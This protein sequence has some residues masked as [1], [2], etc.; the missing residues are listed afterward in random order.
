[1]VMLKCA[2]GLVTAELDGH[3]IVTRQALTLAAG[4]S[5]RLIVDAEQVIG[6]NEGRRI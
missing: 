6:F 3:T 4:D 2:V 1:M 5:G